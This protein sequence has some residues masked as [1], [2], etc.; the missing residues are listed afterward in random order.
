MA[1]TNQ[2]KKHLNFLLDSLQEQ[3]DNLQTLVINYVKQITKQTREW[4]G[5]QSDSLQLTEIMATVSSANSALLQ[6][7]EIISRSGQHLY[8]NQTEEVSTKTAETVSEQQESTMT[9]PVSEDS[10][11]FI[12]SR[13]DSVEKSIF[14]LKETTLAIQSEQ[15]DIHEWK[16][17]IG[18]KVTK[19]SKRQKQ[20]QNNIEKTMEM[21][22]DVQALNDNITEFKSRMKYLT[23][24]VSKNDENVK[25]EIKSLSEKTESYI[26]VTDKTAGFVAKLLEKDTTDVITEKLDKLNLQ[27]GVMCNIVQQRLTP[28]EKM[29]K[30]YQ[31]GP[32]IRGENSRKLQDLKTEFSH[33]SEELQSLSLHITK[34]EPKKSEP[35]TSSAKHK[36]RKSA[37]KADDIEDPF[38]D[39]EGF[40]KTFQE[41]EIG[42]RSRRAGKEMEKDPDEKK[43]PSLY[44]RPCHLS[45]QLAAVVGKNEMPRLEVV[46]TLWSIVKERNLQD[47]NDKKY[48]LCDEQMEHLFG[49]KRIKLF[50]MMD[51]LQEHI[52]D[53]PYT[54]HPKDPPGFSASLYLGDQ[55]TQ[56]PVIANFTWVSHT[57]PYFNPLTGIFTAPVPGL[58]FTSLAVR[59]EEASKIWVKLVRQQG[60]TRKELISV[61]CESQGTTGSNTCL[62]HMNVGDLLFLRLVSKEEK[63]PGTLYFIAFRIG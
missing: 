58:Y 52:T 15:L 36:K 39:D 18:R 53:I 45:D 43:K 8:I 60:I 2:S 37:T 12:K 59:L 16:T 46:K 49:S 62:I 51:Y 5:Q 17:N 7:I 22:E 55:P 4:L 28:I 30:C 31:L 38:M 32:T 50:A 63:I 61:F 33:M 21:Q 23:L 14:E 6:T 1:L 57:C 25:K 42:L 27:Y 44:F 54:H 41:E 19:L 20:D 10:L 40:A 9:Q 11:S 35:T 29:V 56:S 13:L 34:T 47:P 26:K 24:S 48:M 3:Q